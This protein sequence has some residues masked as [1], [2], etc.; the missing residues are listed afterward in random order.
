MSSKF[1]G[2]F[3]K[4]VAKFLILF[5][6]SLIIIN[7]FI[8]NKEKERNEEAPNSFTKQLNNNNNNN[9]NLSVLA[10]PLV[11]QTVKYY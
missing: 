5:L 11:T 7:R 2:S 8:L 1:L 4:A 6:P 9:N 3:T 10:I